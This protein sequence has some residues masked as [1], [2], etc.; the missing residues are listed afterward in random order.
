[1][2]ETQERRDAVDPRGRDAALAQALQAIEKQFGR[3]AIMR[4]DRDPEPVEV[5]RSGSLGLDLALGCGGYPR[6]RIIEI[7][8][9][10]ASGKTTLTLHALAEMQAAGGTCAFVD[11]EHAL[12]PTY[13]AALGVRVD[14]L[15]L[16]QPDDGEQ[17]LDIVEALV[18]SNAVDLVVVDSVAALV[19]RDEIEGNMGDA[20]VGLHARM[21]SKAMR[22][23]T[24]VVSRSRCT[25]MFINQVRQKI[26]V[27]FGPTEVTTGGNALKYYASVR[28]DVR[29]V[30]TL[31]RA[32]LAVGARTRVKVVKNKLAPPFRQVE[33]DIV[34]GRGVHRVAEVVDLAEAQ[35]VL[36]RNG[37]WYALGDSRLANGRDALVA[38]LEA[39][40]A[41]RG[42]VTAL[43]RAERMVP[44]A[45][46]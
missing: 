42:R 4:L 1:M 25:L 2:T 12:D 40:A 26:G 21:M 19:P 34:F 10:E 43:L 16:S 11:A 15:L 14:Q 6:G 24:T 28:L 44:V 45:E 20:Q 31:T 5:T 38:L 33:F 23:L 7:F 9:P 29:R 3:G 37:S 30:K 13:A 32:E 39:D 18:R 35:G 46:A 22:K 17:A 8:G 36:T 27:T 41:L